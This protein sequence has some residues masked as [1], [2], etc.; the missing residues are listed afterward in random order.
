M[1]R[2]ALLLPDSLLS[3]CSPPADECSATLPCAA[4]FTSAAG[5]C[6]AVDAGTEELA[7]PGFYPD[8]P[9]ID[10]IESV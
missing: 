10:A 3:S 2:F 6:E 9:W 1:T 4:G 8:E 7:S 5:R